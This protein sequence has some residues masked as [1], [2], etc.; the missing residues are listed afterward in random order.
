[1][2]AWHSLAFSA[3]NVMPFFTVICAGCSKPKIGI[4]VKAKVARSKVVRD[5]IANPHPLH[6]LQVYFVGTSRFSSS[7]Q[8]WTTTMRGG[9]AR[10]PEASAFLSITNRFPSGATS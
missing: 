8:F 3:E 1:V 9:V 4:A 7:N 5:D 6:G 2:E 10:G